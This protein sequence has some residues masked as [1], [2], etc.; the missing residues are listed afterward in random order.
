MRGWVHCLFVCAVLSAALSASLPAQ[1]ATTGYHSVA[2]IKV[3]PENLECSLR[4][5]L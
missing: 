1:Q 2:C 4:G 3:T 5:T